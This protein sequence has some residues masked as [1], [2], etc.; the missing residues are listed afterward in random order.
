ML[1][2]AV[3][4]ALSEGSG[5]AGG[6]G[7]EVVDSAAVGESASRKDEGEE[8]RT[9]FVDDREVQFEE[10]FSL[11]PP[12]HADLRSHRVEPNLRPP[13]DHQPWHPSLSC[14]RQ[15]MLDRRHP[16]P[17]RHCVEPFGLVDEN[18][19]AVRRVIGNAEQ[20]RPGAESLAPVTQTLDQVETTKTN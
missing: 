13:E 9:V 12:T 17:G 3:P 6:A 16:E 5:V 4:E 11:A 19:H 15:T 10:G 20:E 7:E 18:R 1:V 14:F 2:Y 8:P